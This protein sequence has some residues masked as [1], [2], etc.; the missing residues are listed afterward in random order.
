M[1]LEFLSLVFPTL[2]ALVGFPAVVAALINLLKAF[3]MVDGFAPKVSL[4]FNLLGFAGT[5]YLVATNQVEL[6]KQIDA[7]L[8]I[9]AAFLV[10]FTAF[11]I[12]I[13]LTK[14]AHSALRGL[15]LIG[16]SYSLKK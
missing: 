11:V 4:A 16:Y 3:G 14:V 9:A 15:P 12:E 1:N 5:F 8:T 2:L 13:G 6:L 7:Q 10:S